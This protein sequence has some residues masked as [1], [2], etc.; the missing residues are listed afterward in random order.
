MIKSA[1]LEAMGQKMLRYSAVAN[2]EFVRSGFARFRLAR[3]FQQLFPNAEHKIVDAEHDFGPPDNW[4]SAHDWLARARLYD[5]YVIMLSV[6]IDIGPKEGRIVKLKPPDFYIFEVARVIKGRRAADGSK[7]ELGWGTF[8][9]RDW[10]KLIKAKGRFSVLDAE[11]T[12]DKPVPRFDDYWR[13]TGAGWTSGA[14]LLGAV[15]AV[16]RD[17]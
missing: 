15:R 11:L 14:G 10:L 9:H 6:A 5:R 4:R 2:Q 7:Y 16:R 1:L 8:T 17:G 3:Q 12:K 13:E